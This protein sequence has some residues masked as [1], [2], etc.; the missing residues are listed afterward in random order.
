MRILH[1]FMFLLESPK[2]VQQLQN[3]CRLD[4]GRRTAQNELV[5]KSYHIE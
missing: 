2:M 3:M 1:A 4:S 5:V